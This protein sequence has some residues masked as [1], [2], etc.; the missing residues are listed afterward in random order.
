MCILVVA[1]LAASAAPAYAQP[2]FVVMNTSETPPDGVWFRYGPDPGL[3]TKT[4]GLGVY[5]GEHVSVK[6]YV[7]GTPFGPYGND[8]WYY[9]YDVERPSV[10][11]QANEGWI[12]THYV[13]DG[14]AAD[15]PNPAVGQCASGS[16]D[17][18]A[19]AGAP[20]PAFPEGASIFFQ[21]K[22]HHDP[23]PATRTVE[24]GDWRAPGCTIR[25]AALADPLVGRWVSVLAG[26][27]EAR[28]GPVYFLRSATAEQAAHVHYVLIV[29]P[30][31]GSQFAGGCDADVG[32]SAVLA[33]W[34]SRDPS[35]RLVVVSAS[36]TARD[37]HR[38]LQRY[39]LS[40]I[41][42]RHLNRQ[43]LVCN[44]DRLGHGEAFARY[45]GRPS[46]SYITRQRF[47][48]PRGVLGWHP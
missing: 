23:T 33:S 46:T 38:G 16:G 14:M 8:V 40:A 43:V 4:D 5:M 7:H 11:G 37:D 19:S 26:W 34:L 6:C 31:P 48:C 39:Y 36:A 20:Q 13:D 27:S 17:G 1:A 18:G 12:N 3:T 24:Y 2:V 35:N 32:P 21:P 28:L 29:D 47:Q 9:A 30:G 45:A 41:K 42:A 15:Q 25:A 44:D 22:G 10:A